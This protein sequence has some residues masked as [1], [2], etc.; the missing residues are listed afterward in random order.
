MTTR[1]QNV[2]DADVKKGQ[3]RLPTKT[4]LQ[5]GLK[6]QYPG[7]PKPSR[8][9]A[10]GSRKETARFSDNGSRSGTIRLGKGTMESLVASRCIAVGEQLQITPADGAGEFHLG[11]HGAVDATGGGATGGGATGGASRSVAALLPDSG[12]PAGLPRVK[13]ERSDTFGHSISKTL[14]VAT[15]WPFCQSINQSRSG[16][17]HL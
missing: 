15:P 12:A 5:L 9:W 6:S 17:I 11:R 1:T 2:T 4:V 3:I 8:R 14:I 16:A 10:F 13:W 7:A